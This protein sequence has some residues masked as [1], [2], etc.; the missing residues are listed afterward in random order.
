MVFDIMVWADVDYTLLFCAAVEGQFADDPPSQLA[1]GSQYMFSYQ[2]SEVLDVYSFSC[3]WND[4]FNGLYLSYFWTEASGQVVDIK[5]VTDSSPAVQWVNVEGENMIRVFVGDRPTP[6]PP[7]PPTPGP[8][9]PF[10]D[11]PEVGVLTPSGKVALIACA[12]VI[13]LGLTIA[14]VLCTYQRCRRSQ[15][16]QVA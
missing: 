14:A 3:Q 8:L 11:P 5:A 4:T 12:A 2:G 13:A 6:A 7:T 15:Y 16:E 10:T 1:H 9:G